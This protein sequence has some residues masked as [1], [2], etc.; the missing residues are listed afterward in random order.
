MHSDKCYKYTISIVFQSI[1]KIQLNSFYKI[2]NQYKKNIKPT[3]LQYGKVKNKTTRENHS[4]G[5][6]CKP[7]IVMRFLCNCLALGLGNIADCACCLLFRLSTSH[8][9][10]LSPHVKCN[11][12]SEFLNVSPSD[13]QGFYLSPTML[14]PID[15]RMNCN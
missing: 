11:F 1:D 7:L 5:F 2:R 6:L 3:I 12:E 15:I 4:T 9:E 13:S 8:V 14:I 10:S